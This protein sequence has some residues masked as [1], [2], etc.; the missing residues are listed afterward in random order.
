MWAKKDIKILISNRWSTDSDLCKLLPN[1][2]KYYIHMKRVQLGITY[3]QM[4][5]DPNKK[6]NTEQ[7]IYHI[8][9]K[10][11]SENEDNILRENRDVDAKELIGLLPN[12]SSNAIN[13]RRYR[14]GIHKKRTRLNKDKLK[15]AKLKEALKTSKTLKSPVAEIK[16]IGSQKSLSIVKSKNKK[17]LDIPLSNQ[18]QSYEEALQ[19]LESIRKLVNKPLLMDEKQLII[20]EILYLMSEEKKIN[21]VE[22]VKR[23]ILISL[24]TKPFDYWNDGKHLPLRQWI[25]RLQTVGGY[26]K[27]AA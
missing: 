18:L 8:L 25:D 23:G 21:L 16:K 22:D 3:T 6:P 27:K 14:L 15:S 26:I 11:W 2:S 20:G 19:E 12:R 4:K 1:Q 17:V 24:M 5:K 9:R 13:S 10:K 7:M